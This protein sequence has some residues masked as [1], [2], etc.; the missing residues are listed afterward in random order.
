MKKYLLAVPLLASLLLAACASSTPAAPAAWYDFGPLPA[1]AV[2]PG[3][4]PL[5]LAEIGAPAWL[6]GTGMMYRLAYANPQ[7]PRPYAASRW[8]MPPAQ[9]LAQRLKTRLAAA[10]GVV[11]A[12]ADGALNLPLLRIE[13]DDFS[14]DFAAPGASTAQV[15]VRATWFDGRLL[16]AQKSFTREVPAPSA[17]APGG[18]RALAD[19]SDLLITDLMQWLTTLP[20]KK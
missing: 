10:G 18:A 14:Q 13:L 11:T 4:P 20:R 15:S 1:Q 19:A 16:L 2:L 5:S 12:A 17:D 6:D 8:N 3:L 7:Q 9:L